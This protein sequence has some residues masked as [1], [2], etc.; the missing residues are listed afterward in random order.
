MD[1]RSS[2]VGARRRV[3]SVGDSQTEVQVPTRRVGSDATHPCPRCGLRPTRQDEPAAAA[4]GSGTKAPSRRKVR[5]PVQAGGPRKLRKPVMA[6]SNHGRQQLDG[7]R[8]L[9]VLARNITLSPEL[10]QVISWVGN[11]GL[12]A[13]VCRITGR[14]ADRGIMFFNK[15]CT[16]RCIKKSDKTM[17][18]SNG[19]WCVAFH[20]KIK[21][22]RDGI[23][24][25]TSGGKVFAESIGI[26]VNSACLFSFCRF[27]KTGLHATVFILAL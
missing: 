19:E 27:P 18:L 25:F 15:E 17:T 8:D 12:P 24:R 9:F 20:G 22:Y 7:G 14:M 11:S 2:K 5:V 21:V 1:L 4:E 13:Y 23:A 10:L 3:E 26:T 6:G 16:S